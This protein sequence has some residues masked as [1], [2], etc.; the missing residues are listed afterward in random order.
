MSETVSL[1][2]SI[3]EFKLSSIEYAVS[4]AYLSVLI[5]SLLLQFHT[6]NG[7]MQSNSIWSKIR[8]T[9]FVQIN[10]LCHS[11]DIKKL[12]HSFAITK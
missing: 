4:S 11:D 7:V 5:D 12:S 2:N 10:G 6:G 8:S 1:Q 3:C 9:C